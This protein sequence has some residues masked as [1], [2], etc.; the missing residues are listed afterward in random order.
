MKKI[1]A[2]F[3]AFF[4]LASARAE[5]FSV[6]KKEFYSKNGIYTLKAG[7]SGH[8]G[9]G[10]A[11]LELSGAAGKKLSVFQSD[12]AP[13]TVTITGDGR[14][15]FFFCGAWGQS[16]TIYTLDVHSASGELLASHQVQMQGPAGE[17]LSEDFSIYAL[18]A[19]QGSSWSILVLNAESGGLLWRKKFK[20]KLVGLKLSG[21]G[22]RLLAVFIAGEA[23]RRAVIF[24]K[25]GKELWNRELATANNLVPKAFSGDGSELEL[26]ESRM[27]Y[28]E[29]DGYWHDKVLKKHGYRFTPDGGEEA[30]AKAGAEKSK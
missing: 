19:D 6:E 11:R 2:A 26:W 8:G 22:E 25:A 1:L 14:R 5:N 17:D 4:C 18:G 9:G 10:R 12:R 29:K 27:V 15:L 30:G 24:D 13:F 3:L 21:S 28:D 20:E 16:V 7:Y 23:S